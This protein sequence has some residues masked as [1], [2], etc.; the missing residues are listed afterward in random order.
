MFVVE[1]NPFRDRN[2]A[3]AKITHC[4]GTNSCASQAAYCTCIASVRSGFRCTVPRG[5]SLVL[6]LAPLFWTT[7]RRRGAYLP[8]PKSFNTLFRLP[9]LA[10]LST[11]GSLGRPP[12]RPVHRYWHIK[13]HEKTEI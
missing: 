2:M 5:S 7:G 13:K 11:S 6:L 12:L 4:H 9:V 1:R 3:M 8:L 10:L